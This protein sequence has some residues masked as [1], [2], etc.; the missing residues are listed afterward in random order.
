MMRETPLVAFALSMALLSV[1]ASGG[2]KAAAE[3]RRDDARFG[4]LISLATYTQCMAGNEPERCGPEPARQDP[5]TGAAYERRTDPHRWCA[6]FERPE[7][8]RDIVDGSCVLIGT[9]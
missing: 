4:Q 9:L 1:I 5:F 8:R 2:P 7:E 6:T 3:S